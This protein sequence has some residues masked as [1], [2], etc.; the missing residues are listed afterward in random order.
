M[1]SG[2]SY[3]KMKTTDHVMC[4]IY[5]YGKSYIKRCIAA[6]PDKSYNK[7]NIVDL[8]Y[9]SKYTGNY[10]VF[11]GDYDNLHQIL[12]EFQPHFIKGVPNIDL[13]IE[14]LECECDLRRYRNLWKKFI[15]W[16]YYVMT[17]CKNVSPN[18]LGWIWKS[19]TYENPKRIK[20]EPY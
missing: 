7:E 8:N 2:S 11:D 1:G 9:Y 5:K 3:I 6:H 15:D 4:L 17:L 19:L 13:L 16:K 18:W 12:T 14:R 10:Y 20:L